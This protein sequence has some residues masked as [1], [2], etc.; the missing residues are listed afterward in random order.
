MGRSWR[1]R[2]H[3]DC[4]DVAV[5]AAAPEAGKGRRGPVSLAYPPDSAS[6]LCTARGGLPD[7]FLAGSGDSNGMLVRSTHDGDAVTSGAQSQPR[8]PGTTPPSSTPRARPTATEA[9]PAQ[10]PGRAGTL[11][12]LS[13][14]RCTPDRSPHKKR[15][16]GAGRRAK[17]AAPDRKARPAAAGGGTQTAGTIM[18]AA[19]SRRPD[20]GGDAASIVA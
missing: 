9:G 12:R 13:A 20:G 2:P 19:L 14:A 17:T 8:R 11:V 6:K 16:A 5:G 3:G 7:S 15:A 4:P 10:T 1:P 18:R